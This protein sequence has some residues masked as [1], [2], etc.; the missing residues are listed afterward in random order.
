[1]GNI[2]GIGICLVQQNFGLVKLDPANYI[3]RNSAIA[4]NPLHLVL[5]NTGAII[6][7]F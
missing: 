5:L 7:I 2:L 4:L 3:S 1:M 6:A